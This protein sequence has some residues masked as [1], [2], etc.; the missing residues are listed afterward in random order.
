M[1]LHEF[2]I[3]DPRPC[4]KGHRNTVSRCNVRVGG[5]AI[6][7]PRTSGAKNGAAGSHPND[8]AAITQDQGPCAS[9]V[10]NVEINRERKLPNGNIRVGT[11]LAHQCPLDLGPRFI[12]RVNNSSLRMP[13]LEGQLETPGFRIK[14]PTPT[15]KF[16]DAFGPLGDH[17]VHCGPFANAA[18]NRES[19]LNMRRMGVFLAEHSGHA[20]LGV[21]AIALAH[22]VLGDD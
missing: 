12:L 17:N 15:D 13:A 5:F 10:V 19:V 22:R 2:N 16:S 3:S 7:A 8:I 1:K 21:I 11:N 14:A 4:P 9:K 18:P 6:E 20:T